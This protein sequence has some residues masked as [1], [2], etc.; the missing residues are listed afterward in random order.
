[1]AAADSTREDEWILL[2]VASQ[3]DMQARDSRT[4]YDDGFGHFRVIMR[5]QKKLVGRRDRA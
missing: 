3:W 5:V 2:V 4:N 1:M